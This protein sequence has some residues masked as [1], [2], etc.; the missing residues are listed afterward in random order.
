MNG[1]GAVPEESVFREKLGALLTRFAAESPTPFA[2]AVRAALGRAEA[3]EVRLFSLLPA[4]DKSHLIQLARE[5][6]VRG[7][8][9]VL[10]APAGAGA[11][12]GV[13]AVE[14]L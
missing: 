11:I 8:W 13:D 10:K 4:G 9:V 7:M 12:P 3:E 1:R 2:A 5:A 6:K 14:V